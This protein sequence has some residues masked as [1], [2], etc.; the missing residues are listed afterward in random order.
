MFVSEIIDEVLETL[1]TTD[2]TKAY[3]KL[4]QAVQALMQS[5]HYFHTNAEVDVC[6][7]WDGMTITLPRGV[8]VPLGVNVDGSPTYFRN[9]LF[10]YH[11]NKGGMY[12]PVQWAWDDRGM[13]A[14][15]MD[16]R[17]PAQLVAVAEHEADAGKIIRVVGT[18]STNRELR[19]QSADG[20][21]LDGL[22]V[23]IH[24]Q[25]DFP[26]GTIAPDGVTIVTRSVQVHPITNLYN[27]VEHQLSSGQPVTLVSSVGTLPSGLTD[28]QKYYA[29]VV[30]DNT[31]ELHQSELDA[32]SGINPVRMTSVASSLTVTLE[33]ARPINLST[34]ISLEDGLPV[35]PISATNEV[36][37]AR[38]VGSDSIDLIVL[39][40]GNPG[41]QITSIYVQTQEGVSSA[42]LIGYN[43]QV[44]PGD[45]AVDVAFAIIN[46]ITNSGSGY[47]A[48]PSGTSTTTVSIQSPIQRVSLVSV[49]VGTSGTTP[50]PTFGYS[51]ITGGLLPSPLIE[52]AT[53][54]VQQLDSGLN[55]VDLQVYESLSDAQNR[56]NPIP[57][58]GSAE[59][60]TTY[61]RKPFA[62]QTKL[63]FT[64][65]PNFSTGDTVQANTNGGTLPQPLITGT[66]YYVHVLAEDPPAVTLH[67]TYQDAI[68][69]NDPI[70]LLTS[71]SGQNSIAKL[72]TATVSPGTKNNVSV[73]G[74]DLPPASGSG[75][76]VSAQA[77]G[78]VTQLTLGS[79][80][81]GYTSATAT[82]TDVGGYGYTIAPSI[83]LVGGNYTAGATLSAAITTDAAS[84][85]GY[86]S[87]VSVMD[88]GQGY[89]SANAP[90]LTFSGG[91]IANGRPPNASLRIDQGIL[92][93]AG[94]ALTAGV[95]ITDGQA[96]LFG[97]TGGSGTGA[98]GYMVGTGGSSYN[99]KY[100]GTGYKSPSILGVF[101]M[102]IKYGFA[103][104]TGTGSI[105]S[106]KVK[107]TASATETELIG[108]TAVASFT[109]TAAAATN[110]V[111][112][113]NANTTVSGYCALAASNLVT[114][115]PALFITVATIGQLNERINNIYVTT[116]SNSGASTGT[117]SAKVDLFAG[118]AYTLLTGDIASP[119]TMATA[120]T[121]QINS[122]TSTTGYNATSSGAVICI[123]PP[124]GNFV[125]SAQVVTNGIST[126]SYALPA[127]STNVTVGGSNFT[128][129]IL[130]APPTFASPLQLTGVVSGVD[131]LP[132]G[133]GA[134]ATVSINSINNAVNG[135]S[136]TAT[137]SGYLYPP[138]VVISAP[139]LLN[140]QLTCVSAGQ[141]TSGNITAIT[142]KL[143]N[144]TVTANLMAAT[145][146]NP[147]APSTSLVAAGI[148]TQI[149]ANFTTTGWT[150][151]VLASSSDTVVIYPPSGVVVDSFS[152]TTQGTPAM[153]FTSTV[154]SQATAAASVTTSFVT[155]YVVEN[156]G[157]GYTTAPAV[158]ISGG[159]GTGA[160]A[161]ATID[162]FG[163]GSITVNSPGTGYPSGVTCYIIDT[164]GGT[165]TGAT[166]FPTRS[167]SG[168][169]SSVT[170][171]NPGYGYASP[172]IVFVDPAGGTVP[173][174]GT[175]LKVSTA[176]STS[177]ARLW[178]TYNS[179]L[180]TPSLI[181]IAATTT[182]ALTP[183]NQ[184]AANIANEINRT[185]APSATGNYGE[186][187]ITL[188]SSLSIACSAGVT[189]GL[190]YPGWSV[191]GTNIGA[192]AT[193]TSIGS[194]GGGTNNLLTLS[195]P[196]A[197]LVN[198][199]VSISTGYTAS[200][201][202]SDLSVVNISTPYGVG[203]TG[204]YVQYSGTF[205]YLLYTGA[206]VSFEY[207]G[208]VTDVN[209]VTEGT[210]YSSVPTVKIN[211]STGVFVEFSATGSLPSPLVQGNS[212][213][214]ENPSSGS[215]FTLKNADFSDVNIT[216]TGSG[217]LFL[218][219][220][221]TF[222]IGFT[223]KWSGDFTG[224]FSIPVR[225]QTDYQLPV[226]S[227]ATDPYTT[228]YL[229]KET[230]NSAGL[231]L[232]SAGVNQISI[233]Q[234]GVGQSYFAVPCRSAAIVYNDEMI[235]SYL[236]YLKTGM[237]VEFRSSD[238]ILPSPLVSIGS[239]TISVNSGKITVYDQGSQVEFTDLG[240]GN[241]EIV[242]NRTFFLSG[243]TLATSTNCIFETGDE[244]TV[245]A[246]SG[247]ILPIPL[248]ASSYDSPVSYFVRRAGASDLELYTTK[249]QAISKTSSAGLIEFLSVGNT[250]DSF[251]YADL[252]QEQTLVKA[253]Q[254][255][256]KPQTVGYVSLYAFDYGRAND[257]ALIGQY[258]PSE[259]NPKY[260]RIRIGKPCAWVRMIYRVKSPEI[261]SGYDYIPLECARAIITAVHAIDLEDKDFLE[262]SQKYWQTALAY[263]KN[264]TESMDGHAMSVPQI[265]NITFG[266][267]TDCVMF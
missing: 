222:A 19:S 67:K 47:I 137:G 129:S 172:A 69:G 93:G 147:A 59:D 267:G 51:V 220:S 250:A 17:Q 54:F 154:P 81:G 56:I 182:G 89:D 43:V 60:I 185:Y 166:A 245:R 252:I 96:L 84:G 1:G 16:I 208:V 9:R 160:T 86:V 25:S 146:T 186:Y 14:T 27:A 244:I 231:Y 109:T 94:S 15:Q 104:V 23:T 247:D 230:D 158:S 18:D 202:P 221:R 175:S 21:G 179:G 42:N 117:T 61:I 142:A 251:F 183:V 238:G 131:L 65:A 13:V 176:A 63:V 32:K 191:T 121:T 22:L 162:K 161:T 55:S 171:T 116:L 257:M 144:G 49:L 75:A 210:G 36:T 205:T 103:T 68:T 145:Y 237:L 132:Y 30:D 181:S 57:L 29:G 218:V 203:V 215:S 190:S 97:D 83:R 265:N 227:P 127:Y 79:G 234:L 197:G 248:Q 62:P 28:K 170:V 223:D 133:S 10:Q 102:P 177:L 118:A 34:A 216:S 261:T 149:A 50:S 174:I 26:Y 128:P 196:N 11:I 140:P 225:L 105:N 12:N 256:E 152:T 153:S 241:V 201:S 209:V 262:Q 120:I 74:L 126:Y 180:L 228:Y 156:S 138:R 219:L 52:D 188:S 249:Q 24:A 169:I 159:G 199:A 76:I 37:F 163:L 77:S 64:A 35:V 6:S 226:T 71:G 198:G 58:I 106:V 187:T 246:S 214:A 232:D 95:G 119:T 194:T 204:S 2:R 236:D 72:L 38:R 157:S 107:T 136:L 88:G 255:I 195:V 173:S 40:P 45:T 85:I 239:Y 192:G 184:L 91:L 253:I 135:V 167:I 7:G 264:E 243:Q 20:T 100:S 3:R 115:T 122:K 78:P 108:G 178:L 41:A 130:Y 168:G 111:T 114:I 66:N 99:I 90:R 254:H 213:R 148:A 155:K 101:L 46:A 33:D 31:I 125:N 112:A 263:L 4:S 224:F 87:S 212:Y 150:A 259:T 8:E 235:P 141:A 211:P 229:L 134:T 189:G 200:V 98:F 70:T 217:T 165:G 124:S 258:H 39:T 193:I 48:S 44:Y 164:N 260:R 207:T 113:I 266:D 92:R 206:S 82:I 242:V 143:K 151:A 110:L 233:L 5:G 80:G 139:N 53:Y 240:H 73:T 123:R